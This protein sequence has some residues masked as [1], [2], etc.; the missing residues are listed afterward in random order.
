MNKIHPLFQHFFQIYEGN[1][2]ETGV[3]GTW[4]MSTYYVKRLSE[5]ALPTL[6]EQAGQRLDFETAAILGSGTWQL[7]VSL[8]TSCS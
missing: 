5:P 8:G 1:H 7:R 6:L 4:I 2:I 3:I